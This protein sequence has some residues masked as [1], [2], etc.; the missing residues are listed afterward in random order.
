MKICT[1]FLVTI[2]T[3][4]F[5]YNQEY[6]WSNPIMSKENIEFMKPARE[7]YTQSQIQDCQNTID[8]MALKLKAKLNPD[9]SPEKTINIIN[10]FIF[11]EC[12]FQYEKSM[13]NIDF[14]LIPSVIKSRKGNCL[15]L[16]T[17][18]IILGEK[19]GLPL[20]GAAAPNHFFVIYEN[21]NTHINIETADEGHSHTDTQYM[22]RFNIPKNL[23]GSVYLTKLDKEKSFGYLESNL[24]VIY[25]KR[26]E[27]D[28]SIEFMKSA[29]NHVDNSP[30][31]YSNIGVALV[32]TGDAKDAIQYFK[33][34]LS[35]LPD[36][37]WTHA[38]LAQ[39]YLD[40]KKESLA[41]SEYEIA[42]KLNPS[43]KERVKKN[44]EIV[45]YNQGKRFFQA[46]QYS[47][48]VKSYEK[49]LTLVPTD[50]DVHNNLAILYFMLKDYSKALNHVKLAEKYGNPVDPD[51]LRAIQNAMQGNIQK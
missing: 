51:V 18:Y 25:M 29:L 12:H 45:Y 10:N 34:S 16:S 37:A 23:I 17:L 1:L 11:E 22:E 38:N 36:E 39:A 42:I 28:K 4:T 13:D 50:S 21:S 19:L 43:L 33:K 20:Y 5:V 14:V 6:S 35:I 31:L 2:T 30:E 3:I 40:E 48:A 7:F 46:N 8:E 24:G 27:Y 47:N 32:E 26:K 41:E 44:L 49:Y 9:F 15:G